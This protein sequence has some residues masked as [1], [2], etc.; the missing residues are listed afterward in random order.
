MQNEPNFHRF[1]PENGDFTEKRT[2]NEPKTKPNEPNLCRFWPENSGFTE[3][4]TQNEP[5]F[6][7]KMRLQSQNEP[8]FNRL[9]P[10]PVA[11]KVDE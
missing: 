4:R 6:G 1:W 3:K 2:Q 8:N 9:A 5:N 11:E 10:P 7:L